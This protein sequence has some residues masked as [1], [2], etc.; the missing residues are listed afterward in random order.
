MICKT[1]KVAFGTLLFA[2]M[3]LMHLCAQTATVCK[4]N[5]SDPNAVQ[6]ILKQLKEKTEQLQ[7]YQGKVEYLFNQPLLESK[8]LKKGA[9]YYAKYGTESR[10]RINFETLKQDDEEEQKYAEQFIFDGIWLTHLDYKIENA[11]RWQITEPNKPVDAFE[12]AG[13]S[14][15]II[16]FT[17]VEDL[18]KHFEM[19]LVDPNAKKPQSTSATEKDTGEFIHLHFKTKPDSAYKND[20]TSIDLW[21]DKKLNLPAKIV[22]V[23]TEEDI[24]EI[25]LLKTVVNKEIDRKTFEFEIPKSFGEPQVTPLRKENK[26]K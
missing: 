8:T 11:E 22:T 7:S 13:R 10:L 21:I 1:I 20:Y 2:G 5:E 17:K 15:P 12:L 6:T 25:K 14:L 9:I 16:G 24:S 19:T 4:S 26:E 3:G 23:S 18:H